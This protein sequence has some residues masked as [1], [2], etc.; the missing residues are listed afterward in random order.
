[1]GTSV[2]ECPQCKRF[3]TT[4]YKNKRM[5]KF[6]ARYHKDYKHDDEQKPTQFPTKKG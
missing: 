5:M 3:V 1:M 6:V 2:L 4:F